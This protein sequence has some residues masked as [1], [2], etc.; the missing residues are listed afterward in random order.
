MYYQI[1]TIINRTSQLPMALQAHS[2]KASSGI[3]KDQIFGFLELPFLIIAIVFCFLTAKR[4]K[5][6]KFGSG[7]NVIAWG[8][9]VMAI[10]HIHMQIDHLY[11]YNLFNTLLGDTVG[12]FAWFTALILTW[13][14]SAFGF[15]KIY[16]AS[17]I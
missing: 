8:F 6:G 15:Y 1:I 3:S 7:M 12:K 16:K 10:G 14:L 11:S 9:L 13:A 4:L 2:H 17:K 5:G